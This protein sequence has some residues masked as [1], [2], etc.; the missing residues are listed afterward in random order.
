MPLD[1]DYITWLYSQVD[2]EVDSKNK[3]TTYWTLLKLLYSREFTWSR[4]VA[5]DANRAHDGTDLR[6]EFIREKDISRANPNWISMPCSV[7]EMMVA[8]AF[9]LEWDSDGISQGEWFWKLIDNIGL[10]ECTDANPPDPRIVENVLD[11]VISRTYARN[12][13]GGLFPLHQSDHDQREVELAYQA[14]EYLLAL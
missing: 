8:L 5:K 7:L 3:A 2:G 6:R 4:R 10:L 12:G 13:A 11:M 14:Q 1:D 9:K